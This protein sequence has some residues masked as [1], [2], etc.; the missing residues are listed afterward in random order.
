MFRCCITVHRRPLF[1]ADVLCL[2]KVESKKSEIEEKSARSRTDACE[3]L[4]RLQPEGWIFTI[5]ELGA[6]NMEK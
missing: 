1:F 6:G 4:L 2:S 3:P 5:E